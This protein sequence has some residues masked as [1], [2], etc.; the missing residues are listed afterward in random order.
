MG[1][2]FGAGFIIIKLIQD[3]KTESWMTPKKK[4][5]FHTLNKITFGSNMMNNSSGSTLGKAFRM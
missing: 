1:F 5:H 2:V 3:S 4:R